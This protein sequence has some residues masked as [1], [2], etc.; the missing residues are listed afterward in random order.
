MPGSAS[1]GVPCLSPLALVL[2]PPAFCYLFQALGVLQPRLPSSLLHIPGAAT[3]REG[4]TRSKWTCSWCD[5]CPDMEGEEAGGVTTTP[6][7][8]SLFTD[9]PSVSPRYIGC[10]EP[11]RAQPLGKERQGWGDRNCTPW[12]RPD[13]RARRV[14]GGC[15]QHGARLL[16]SHNY[17]H[18]GI[19]PLSQV[20][21]MVG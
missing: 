14:D 19:M 10:V 18:L 13:S 17:T 5:P 3:A 21:R 4:R 9:G 2:E 15:V 7:T 11:S 12:G 1:A 16:K 8:S 20:I 6:H